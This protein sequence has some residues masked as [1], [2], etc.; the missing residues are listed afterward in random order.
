MEIASMPSAK[1]SRA[2]S[3]WG[4][5]WL[6]LAPVSVWITCF[7]SIYC[8][9][10]RF[11][12][13]QLSA[14]DASARTTMKGAAKCDKRCELQNSVNQQGFERILCFRDIPESIPASVSILLISCSWADAFASGES[15]CVRMCFAL[16]VWITYI[17]RSPPSN[18]QSISV[19]YC[20]VGGSHASVANLMGNFQRHEVRSANPLNLSI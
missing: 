11:C 9:I 12:K 16:D 1:R 6:G 4:P 8:I 3:G 15:L 13:L 17:M 2:P 19:A 18:R 10:S 14:T 7:T 20:W 5:K